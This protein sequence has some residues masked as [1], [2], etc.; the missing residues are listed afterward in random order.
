MNLK[1]MKIFGKVLSIILA[2]V[3]VVSLMPQMELKVKAADLPSG[4]LYIAKLDITKMPGKTVDS[5]TISGMSNTG[6]SSIS[7]SAVLSGTDTAPVLTL[8]NF[9]ITAIG[10][11]SKF[12]SVISYVGNAPLT[13]V[14]NGEN[15]LT[16]SDASGGL[17]STIYFNKQVTI[18]GNGDD[19]R[20]SL[21][22]ISNNPNDQYIMTVALCFSNGGVTIDGVDV[23]LIGG[24]ST[25]N[26]FN[27]TGY[28]IRD[29]GGT[30]N[31][32]LEVKGNGK[33]TALA[34]QAINSSSSYGI[35]A[36]GSII[37][38]SSG[39]LYAQAANSTNT[40]QAVS[41]QQI[42]LLSGSKFTAIGG[43]TNSSVGVS[44]SNFTSGP[45]R[46]ISIDENVSLVDIRGNGK[47]MDIPSQ[48][49]IN[50]VIG[51]AWTNYAGTTGQTIVSTSST[52]QTLDT[53]I[54]KV[55]F[56]GHEHD[57][58]Y[59]ISDDD[60]TIIASCQS[61][62]CT[63]TGAKVEL[64]INAPEKT[65]YGDS[66]S[67]SATLTGLDDFVAA[68]KKT[69]AATDI[70]YVGRGDTN[71]TKSTTAPTAAGTYTAE[72]TVVDNETPYTASVN[73]EI[74]KATASLSYASSASVIK[75]YGDSAFINT[76]TN[77]G[78]GTETISYVSSDTSV[79]TVDD[80]GEVTIVG[81][82]N[83]TITASVT[84]SPNHTYTDS[85]ANYVLYVNKANMT[86]SSSGYTGTCDGQ[87]H[88][89][90]V[91]V[92]NPASDY[93]ITYGL[94]DG[95]YDLSENPQISTV[96]ESK[97][98]YY[99][100][101]APN[102]N[103]VTGSETVTLT[104]GNQTITASD[105][106]VHYGENGNVNASTN[107]DGVLSYAV[108]SGSENYI[109]VDSTTGAFTIKAVPEN[110]ENAYVTVS[111]TDTDN[112]N[113]TTQDVAFY[114]SPA[115]ITIG[116]VD[117]AISVGDALP[118]LSLEDAYTV[119]GLVGT[120]TLTTPPTLVYQQSGTAVSLDNPATATGTY[121]IVPSGADASS[122]Y[123]ITYTPGTLTI[124]KA[125]PTVTAPVAFD[126]TYNG[127][128][129]AL[130]AAGSTSAGEMQYALGNEN[131]PTGT[132]STEV[133]KETDAGTY[134]VWYKVVGTATHEDVNQ[135]LVNAYIA[136]RTISGATVTLSNTEFIFDDQAHSVTVDS[137]TLEDGTILDENTHY[138]VSGDLT[139]TDKGVYTVTVTA[140][141][142]NYAE[143][144]STTWSIGLDKPVIT[145]VPTSTP[146][147]Y[148]QKLGESLLSGGA[149]NV[150]GTFVWS[151]GEIYPSV[152]DSD[153]TLYEV[154]FY[155]TDT[156][157]YAYVTC[158]I[159]VTVNKADSPQDNPAPIAP[160]GL[161]DNGQLQELITPVPV[162]GGTLE[163]VVVS[164]PSTFPT[165]GWSP[166][167]PT[168]SAP[169]TYYVFYKVVGDANHLDGGTGFVTVVISAATAPSTGYIKD[170]TGT[171]EAG[172]DY[173][174]VQRILNSGDLKTLLSI[175]DDE[176][177]QGT[178][179]WLD[180]AELGDS[181]SDT[182]K[183]LIDGAKGDYAVG[184]YLD[185]KLFKKVGN[186][187]VVAVTKTNG[188]VKISI[189]IPER[190][191]NN[192]RAFEV[193]RIH[194]GVAT[195][196]QGSF[197][198]STHIFT[199]ESDRFS[200]YAIAYKEGSSGGSSSGNSN[201]AATN[202]DV[203]MPKTDGQS[204]NMIWYILLIM[205]FGVLALLG[206]AG[207]RRIKNNN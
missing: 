66:N 58:T 196:I 53:S 181:V 193:V 114:I 34:T 86:V 164:D 123:T 94:T 51:K 136:P 67:A 139:G 46:Q 107:G 202:T 64:T 12:M 128:E 197:D 178:K 74:A 44:L 113:S 21:V 171:S 170:V 183:A 153:I 28:G 83:A 192:G 180:V 184:L 133:P 185:I 88:S 127:S 135:M 25:G 132:W 205:S 131:G 125:Q 155:P 188:K 137:V 37:E 87:N 71:Y 36:S 76:L 78:D 30:I 104:K 1:R 13:I 49:L 182:D 98:V 150:D 10:D 119:E 82:G 173:T 149:A 6:I 62:D 75:T 154:T 22:A 4:K 111:A 96:S 91:N 126:L 134:C 24:N 203:V 147:T 9:N 93:T 27:G 162:T 60:D 195:V 19:V 118:D 106:Y 108:K 204:G 99:K 142:T 89:I 187:D 56:P 42:N 81:N 59:G 186:N 146:I 168:A 207:M 157:H 68:T 97:T 103:D 29:N 39:E 148:G 100:V 52:G 79:A 95:T 41:A 54:K 175:S 7:G 151:S 140:I 65:T 38:V 200:T 174:F 90:T 158:K 143:S 15:R 141:N 120:D 166:V 116:A 3:L 48:G 43:S 23:T 20:D 172:G 122:N 69:I 109:D 50:G 16:Q 191:C 176:V 14:L 145:K 102:Y 2:L 117:Q 138:S 77:T 47:A 35:Q 189:V 32:K 26:G 161:V 84:S 17:R 201:A 199:F 72:I 11:S 121:D 167:V 105:I 63:L 152:S 57:F 198:E 70:E 124:G 129:Q 55:V 179:L 5:S 33:L 73:Y 112:Y 110:N 177:N 40:S 144:A 190:L 163:Y 130:V 156:D 115:T 61:E 85:V 18:C 206:F 194:D 165:E 31:Q 8:N 101:T 80:T 159:P 45:A 169:G 160:S 92:T